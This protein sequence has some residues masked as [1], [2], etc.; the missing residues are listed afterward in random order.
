MIRDLLPENLQSRSSL[1][2]RVKRKRILNP[3]ESL[4][5]VEDNIPDQKRLLSCNRVTKSFEKLN[6]N[7]NNTTSN[8]NNTKNY[9]IL[10][11]VNTIDASSSDENYS[12]LNI[13]DL[14]VKNLVLPQSSQQYDANISVMLIPN[15]KRVFHSSTSERFL[16][17]DMT[18]LD[19][20]SNHNVSSESKSAQ[21]TPTKTPVLDPVTRQLNEAILT[22]NKSGDFTGIVFAISHG[23]NINH[24]TSDSSGGLTAIMAAS[25][26]CNLRIVKRLLSH[27]CDVFIRNAKGETPMDI[28]QRLDVTPDM[29][30]TK[31][32]IQQWLQRAALKHHNK[33]VSSLGSRDCKY[34]CSSHRDFDTTHKFQHSSADNEHDGDLDDKDFVY[35]IFHADGPEATVDVSV[36]IDSKKRRTHDLLSTFRGPIVPVEVG[37][38][39]HVIILY[40]EY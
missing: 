36:D 2:V 5:I 18:Q 7:H 10:K 17:V 32:E 13:D 22:A 3:S 40:G 38:L 25:R 12:K 21:G 23:A 29:L 20:V 1:V 19:P 30:S 39:K 11:R 31:F 8:F 27:C 15:K 37:K 6:L 4:C 33:V 16:L 28:A 14:K 26:Q 34:T 35:D 9:I 24:R